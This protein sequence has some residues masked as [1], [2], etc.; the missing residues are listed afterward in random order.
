MSAKWHICFE[1]EGI[2][3]RPG[4]KRTIS[5]AN[6]HKEKCTEAWRRSFSPLALALSLS[7]QHCATRLC[8][9]QFKWIHLTVQEAHLRGHLLSPFQDMFLFISQSAN[10]RLFISPSRMWL[11]FNLRCSYNYCRNHIGWR[12]TLIYLQMVPETERF[13]KDI[14][15]E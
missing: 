10:G 7:K 9:C 13:V 12:F 15:K 2:T 11:E 5:S 1:W 6:I 8:P 4:E 3:G 14:H